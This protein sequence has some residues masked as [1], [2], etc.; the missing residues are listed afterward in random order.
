MAGCNVEIKEYIDY[1]G[2]FKEITVNC[3]NTSPHGNPWLCPKCEEINKGRN[4][5]QEALDAGEYW[6]END[7]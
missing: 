4:W 7:Y 1:S 6:D 5:R 3:G 2:R